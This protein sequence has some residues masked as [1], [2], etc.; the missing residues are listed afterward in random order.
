MPT[1]LHFVYQPA[2]AQMFGPGAERDLDSD[3]GAFEAGWEDLGQ[4]I[5]DDELLMPTPI[6]DN[7]VEAEPVIT[8]SVQP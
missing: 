7:D 3:L 2:E 8:E 4:P 5:S 1:E 6:K